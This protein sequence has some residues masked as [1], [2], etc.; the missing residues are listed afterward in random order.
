MDREC[1]IVRDLL[2]LH[3]ENLD[4]DATRV[5]VDEHLSVCAQCQEC[6]A[7]MQS[8]PPQKPQA[9]KANCFDEKVKKLNKALACKRRKAIAAG[10]AVTIL[11]VMALSF[12]YQTLL[13][14]NAHSL[15][16]NRYSIALAS[17]S[18]GQVLL[19]W[20]FGNS[21]PEGHMTRTY[22]ENG[23]LYCDYQTAKLPISAGDPLKEA[24]MSDLV[25]QEGRLYW[26]DAY[27]LDENRFLIPK[28]SEEMKEIRQGTPE[29]YRVIYKAG[30]SIPQCAAE[31]E[32]EMLS[33]NYA[34]IVPAYQE[35]KM[36]FEIAEFQGLPVLDFA[37]EMK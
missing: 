27:M 36:H 25:V 3:V 22:E 8:D 9:L 26:F 18:N 35:G 21:R 23:I 29:N 19:E 31:V 1:S 6:Y 37:G 7:N 10:A 30:D 14:T 34:R 13:K 33:A 17:L 15:S 11:L 12:A 16:P 32:Q 5:F 4:S 20:S 2:P 28:A 24:M